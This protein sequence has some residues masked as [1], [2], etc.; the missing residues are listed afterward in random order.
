[1]IYTSSIQEAAAKDTTNPFKAMVALDSD[2][3][4]KP[5]FTEFKL[6]KKE[7]FPDLS[8]IKIKTKK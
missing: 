8:E 3:G 7:D 5:T 1:M 2:G 4:F 6:G